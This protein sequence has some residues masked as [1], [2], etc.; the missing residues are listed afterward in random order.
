MLELQGKIM[1]FM[2]WRKSRRPLYMC[3]IWIIDY[4]FIFS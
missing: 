4:G 3:M 1:R 2:A